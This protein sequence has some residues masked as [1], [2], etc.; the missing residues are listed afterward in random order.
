[1]V[2]SLGLARNGDLAY[3]ARQV[4][5][6]TAL[7]DVCVPAADVN[8][9]QIEL[10]GFRRIATPCERRCLGRRGG[11]SGITCLLQLAATPRYKL[12]EQEL[13]REDAYL[14]T[15]HRG[16]IRRDCAARTLSDAEFVSLLSGEG[17]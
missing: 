7:V 2:P 11:T 9:A 4:A 15:F 8:K 10:T 16:R 13:S 3:P 1:M 12:Q 6:R 17:P 5:I 14:E